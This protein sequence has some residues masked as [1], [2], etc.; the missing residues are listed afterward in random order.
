VWLL[1]AGGRGLPIDFRPVG[2]DGRFAGR[3]KIPA[4]ASGLLP[5]ITTIELALANE[6]EV[7][8][9][10]RRAA[11]GGTLPQG[12]GQPVLRGRLRD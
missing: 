8:R 1:G 7:G 11:R 9:A 10:V 3:T 12:V 6:E 4:A 5:S 2:P